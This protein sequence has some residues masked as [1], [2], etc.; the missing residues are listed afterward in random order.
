[1]K[2]VSYKYLYLFTFLNIVNLSLGQNQPPEL[3]EDEQLIEFTANRFTLPN[4]HVTQ[5]KK[6][7]I[8]DVLGDIYQVS[9]EGGK[10]EVLLQDSNWKRG[11]KLSPDGKTL[12]YISDETGEFQ[13]WTYN[14]ETHKKRA[15]PTKESMHYPLSAYWDKNSNLIVPDIK[16][17]LSYKIKNGEETTLRITKKEDR[18]ILNAIAQKISINKSGTKAYI[19][20]KNN[21]ISYDLES[22]N[23]KI[24]NDFDIENADYINLYRF[25]PNESG[26]IGYTGGEKGQNILFFYDFDKRKA[27]TLAE[28]ESMGYSTTL[29][30]DFDFI[31]DNSIILDKEGKIVKMD[32]GT[33]AFKP[34]PI[35][36]EVKK[37]IKKTLQRRPQYIRD[38]VITASVLRNPV[39][40]ANLDII[41][42]VAFG[43][44]HSFSKN[45]SK[46]KEIYPGKDRFEASPSLS[47]NGNYLAYT[48]WDDK[49]GYVYLREISSGK[50]YRLTKKSGR[51]INPT[52]SKNGRTLVYL[53]DESDA[54][55]GSL[56]PPSSKGPIPNHQTTLYKVTL[57]KRKKTQPSSIKKIT[58]LTV[59]SAQPNRY[60]SPI[61]FSNTGKSVFVM[62]INPNIFIPELIEVDLNSHKTINSFPVPY[63]TDEAIVSPDTKHIAFVHNNQV[64]LD[65]F[66]YSYELGFS[67]NSKFI[68]EQYYYKGG[69]VNNIS[70]SK[71]KSI[72][73]IAPSYLYWQDKNILM[74]GSAE[75]VYTYDI[76]TQETKKIADIKVQKP[77]AVPKTQ[78]AL[79]NTQIITMNE[80]DEI[81]KKGTILIK[82][83]RIVAVGSKDQIEI[84]KSYKVFDL[85]GKTILPGLIDVHAHYIAYPSEI[86]FKNNYILLSNLAYGVTTIYDP[87]VNTLDYRDQ[88]Q[89][90][91]T[92]QILGPRVFSSG[93]IIMEKPNEYDFKKISNLNDAERIVL[94][95]KKLG[96]H[97]PI[98]EYSISNR[99]VRK[100]LRTAAENHDMTITADQNKFIPAVSRIIDG[101]SSIE[102]IL[103][104]FSLQEDVL[105][106]V[107]LA[108]INYTPTLITKNFS[109]L[110]YD[111]P[112]WNDSFCNERKLVGKNQTYYT[113]SSYLGK[114]LSVLKNGYRAKNEKN[115]VFIKKQ[116]DFLK[117]IIEK[118]GNISIGAHGTYRAGMN[119][120]W[121]LWSYT[122]TG[123]DNYEAIKTA[124]INGAK[125]LG[126]NE[127]IGSIESNKLADLI[128][129]NKNPLQHIYN[130]T[131]IQ[132]T[133]IDGKM[134]QINSKE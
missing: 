54:K 118:E 110:I 14:I 32:I 104:Y 107:S 11:A 24:I 51:Y 50:E 63:Y 117:Y 67:E 6:H 96:V 16:G 80:E 131:D 18:S 46:I 42:F 66:P 76:R 85:K 20:P 27:T 9:I 105:N 98:K 7:I 111:N 130:T 100:W 128:I 25:T 47:P 115:E 60:F 83:N 13:V 26:F 120:H 10:A 79:T 65:T 40:H 113:N 23:E 19:K 95:F 58:D 88:S 78:Y 77:R 44:L 106:F 125:K 21:F 59:I 36:V 75:E 12:A 119:T 48:T 61:S 84:P 34:I 8:F 90:V 45:T 56:N 43:K 103:S 37:V 69:Y 133:I 2:K 121:E 39:T 68:P 81:I 92:G 109:S 33:G 87:S 101:Y 112:M 71:A 94:S 127:E 30:H 70:L 124:T 102:H 41:Y 55:K 64:W 17:I 1:M 97:G 126:L 123:L 114:C 38:S 129:L 116:I 35:E 29:R 28:L 31:D 52:W 3:Q 93:N 108:K 22:G 89:M 122:L 62:T 86:Q 91:E 49:K 74:W 15:Y 53:S 4:I 57:N 5:D 73:E 134:F 132:W 99:Q 72:Y 82:N